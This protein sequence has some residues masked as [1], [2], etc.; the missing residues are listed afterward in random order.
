MITSQLLLGLVIGILAANAFFA[1]YTYQAQQQS[2]SPADAEG[3]SHENDRSAAAESEVECRHCG[4]EN[5][6]DYRFCRECVS[7]LPGARGPGR[8][9]NRQTGRLSM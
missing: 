9:G 3:P 7:E 2:R 8:P 4:T 1:Y 5:E 6:P